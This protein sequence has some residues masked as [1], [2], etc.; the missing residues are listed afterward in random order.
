[1][2]SIFNCKNNLEISKFRRKFP[3]CLGAPAYADHTINSM[4]S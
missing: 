3:P 2:L 1:M 4:V